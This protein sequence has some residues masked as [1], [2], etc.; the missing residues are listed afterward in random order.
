MT[1]RFSKM[2]GKN[3][4]CP[5]WSC[6][7]E[8]PVDSPPLLKLS[9]IIGKKPKR[10]SPFPCCPNNIWPIPIMFS[11]LKLRSSLVSSV[12]LVCL[13]LSIDSPI[14]ENVFIKEPQDTS[15]WSF[16]SFAK[17]LPTFKSIS[18]IPLSPDLPLPVSVSLIYHPSGDGVYFVGSLGKDK[19]RRINH[20]H[21]C[22]PTSDCTKALATFW[23]PP[24]AS[25]SVRKDL[26]A[27]MKALDMSSSRSSSVSQRPTARRRK[28]SHVLDG[29]L[30]ILG[31]SLSLSANK[32]SS[33]WFS[34][35]IP[36]RFAL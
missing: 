33:I 17:I 27:S 24:T 22:F 18:P 28:R 8:E 2:G 16:R 23:S 36:V 15:F 9:M 21:T 4:E 34:N 35:G 3:Q 12:S 29:S 10:A 11:K 13:F 6:F 20:F 30:I 7:F 5:E 31:I 14:E 25:L 19:Y 32:I 26:A 1:W